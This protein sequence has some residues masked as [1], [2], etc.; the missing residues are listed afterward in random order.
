MDVLKHA[1]DNARTFLLYRIFF[2][3][4]YYYPIFTLLFLDFGLTLSQFAIL[5]S[6]WALTIVLFEIPLGALSDVIG[7][8]KIVIFSAILLNLELL[9]WLF[10]PIDGGNKLFYFFLANRIISGICEAASSGADE[11]LAYDS[12]KKAKLEKKWPSILEKTQRYTSLY[13]IFV[14]LVGAMVYDP[15]II[16]TIISLFGSITIVDQKDCI[17]IP[18]FIN[19]MAALMVLFQAFQFHEVTQTRLPLNKAAKETIK[20]IFKTTT[21]KLLIN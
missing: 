6:I 21:V 13:F 9:I 3:A 12:L 17:K 11:A 7:R 16:N 8:K 2:R 4:R 5:N 18:I 14:L 1:N 20:Y 10:A 19:L 15:N